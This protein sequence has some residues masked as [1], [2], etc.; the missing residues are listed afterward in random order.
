MASL[1]D[2]KHPLELY[3]YL[4]E[5]ARLTTVNE[6]VSYSIGEDA[7]GPIMEPVV[8]GGKTLRMPTAEF[9]KQPDWERYVAFHP[10]SENPMR[11]ESEVLRALRMFM[12]SNF[13]ATLGN[14]M[15]GLIRVAANTDGHKRLSVAASECLDAVPKADAKSV[16]DL[17]KVLSQLDDESVESI[18][19]IINT[20]GSTSRRKLINIYLKRGGQYKGKEHGRVAVVDFPFLSHETMD[21]EHRTIFGVK[22]RVKDYDG[23]RKL[24]AFIIGT[25]EAN[26]ETYNSG[27]NTM[28]APYLTVLLESWF[29]IAERLN[30]IIKIYQKYIPEFAE[31]KYDTSWKHAIE[32]FGLLSKLIPPLDGNVG[33][34]ESGSQQKPE[35]SATKKSMRNL[36]SQ[37]IKPDDV[38]V[39]MEAHP[40]GPAVVA[41]PVQQPVM[42]QQMAPVQQPAPAPAPRS[43]G[44]AVTMDEIFNRPA[45]QPVMQQQMYP[46]T[47]PYNQP[48]P[49]NQQLM[50]SSG[51]SM[52]RHQPQ[53]MVMH[54]PQ[55]SWAGAALAEPQVMAQP[56]QP[57][58]ATTRN[59]VQQQPQYN[60]NLQISPASV[61]MGSGRFVL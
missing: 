58:F 38:P 7:N 56:I 51:N 34:Q 33:V 9:L 13:N 22:L 57:A 6:L 15:E 31:L 16:K 47:I 17:G 54:Q 49:Y 35:P 21:D 37:L 36:N 39:T 8:L 42:V 53:T 48:M 40:A 61:G 11:G 60:S 25:E 59:G 19:K 20:L 46:A 18:E 52:I 43:A 26:D 4:L 14:I 24:F 30:K 45:P 50:V 23:F 2:F 27:T 1:V 28:T 3:P 29:K 55:Q 5:A 44:G 12:V 32:D 10:L 41:A